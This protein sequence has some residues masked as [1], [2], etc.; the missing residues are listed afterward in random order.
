LGPA[1][2]VQPGTPSGDSNPVSATFA[3]SGAL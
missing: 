3:S 1:L 2:N